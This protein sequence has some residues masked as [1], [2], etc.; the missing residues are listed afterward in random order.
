MLNSFREYWRGGSRRE[1]SL[2]LGCG[3][4]VQRQELAPAAP[5][6]GPEV[7]QPVQVYQRQ[8]DES[9]RQLRKADDRFKTALIQ[10]SIAKKLSKEVSEMRL[11]NQKSLQEEIEANLMK[12]FCTLLAEK[13]DH[14]IRRIEKHYYLGP[15]SSE[16]MAQ[17]RILRQQQMAH[18]LEIEEAMFIPTAEIAIAQ[19]MAYDMPHELYAEAYKAHDEILKVVDIIESH[20]KQ[21]QKELEERKAQEKKLTI[22]PGGVQVP[23]TFFSLDKVSQLIAVIIDLSKLEQVSV[24]A[25]CAIYIQKINIDFANTLLKRARKLKDHHEIQA[26]NAVLEKLTKD[27]K[28]SK[29][30]KKAEKTKN[31]LKTLMPRIY[32]LAEHILEQLK[33]YVIQG[34]VKAECLAEMSYQIVHHTS[35]EA[36][37]EKEGAEEEMH[38]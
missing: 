6:A 7:P 38:I 10:L 19:Q 2:G 1:C 12:N 9:C 34:N 29:D 30:E 8:V 32:M 16:E 26:W 31:D 21:I 13:E 20:I 33:A 3:N 11:A 27:D 23:D 24:S 35:V 15:L 28:W 14:R 4:S 5:E 18:P 17:R 36:D 25:R 22:A 37:E